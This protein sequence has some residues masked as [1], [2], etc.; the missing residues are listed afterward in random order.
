VPAST[1]RPPPPKPGRRMPSDD[2]YGDAMNPTLAAMIADG[3]Y[4]GGGAL[5]VILIIF[6]IWMVLRGR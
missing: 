1:P 2:G 3:V 6:V 5:L 4:V